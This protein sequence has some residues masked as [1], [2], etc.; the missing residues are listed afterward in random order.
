VAAAYS[1]AFTPD[2]AQVRVVGAAEGVTA[3]WGQGPGQ[4]KGG[5]GALQRV[6]ADTE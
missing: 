5:S 3:V 6:E 4:R 1:L 2:G